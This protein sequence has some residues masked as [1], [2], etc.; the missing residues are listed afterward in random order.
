ME[1]WVE[2]AVLY[3]S[4]VVVCSALT[5]TE[6][7]Y[8]HEFEQ[9]KGTSRPAY[10]RPQ[11]KSST[12]SSRSDQRKGWMYSVQGGNRSQPIWIS[13]SCQSL[14]VARV[15]CL[16]GSASHSSYYDYVI[17]MWIPYRSEV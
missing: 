16:H 2:V 7:R 6:E 10:L 9:I 15:V 8:V 14:T 17:A 4:L 11:V 12:G 13:A 1:G 3:Y 5:G